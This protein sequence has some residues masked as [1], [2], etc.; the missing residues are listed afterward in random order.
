MPI[1]DDDSSD[2]DQDDHQRDLSSTDLDSEDEPDLGL[3]SDD[4][5]SEE[6][7]WPVGPVGSVGVAGWRTRNGRT[8]SVLEMLLAINVNGPVE[9]YLTPPPNHQTRHWSSSRRPRSAR[10]MGCQSETKQLG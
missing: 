9:R 3:D 2:D 6:E 8:R 10:A 1:A 4:D 5:D 7:Q